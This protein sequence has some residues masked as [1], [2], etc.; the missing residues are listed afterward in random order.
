MLGEGQILGQVRDAYKAADACKTVG[1][2]FHT[3]FQSALRVGKAVRDP[4]RHGPG[5]ALGRQRRGRR[6]PRG[7]RL[8]RRQD[9]AGHRRRQDGRDD[10]AAP[11]GAEPGH[12]PGDQPQP[13]AGRGRRGALGRP[14]RAVRPAGPGADRGRPGHQHHRRQRADRHA[15]AIPAGP[16]RPAQ[17][18]GP[19]P[20]HRHP[21]RL[22]PADRRPRPGDA[23]PRRRPPRPGRAEP[24]AAPEGDRPGAGDHRA[25]D[26]RL[27]RHARG[28][29]TTPGTCSS[30]LGDSL[31]RR[32]AV[33][34]WTSSSPRCRT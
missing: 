32:S 22:R 11:Q 27:L 23:L 19:D 9:R 16:A 29:S 2:I 5:E 8:V 33:A 30:E 13:R 34:S 3:V 24:A 17:P 14:R 7:L 1:P 6:G 31:R 28:T 10:L 25:R 15:R 18:A 21:P 20:R 26:G 12:D 4:D